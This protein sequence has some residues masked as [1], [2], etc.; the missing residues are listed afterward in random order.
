[1]TNRLIPAV[2]LVAMLA[3]VSA[4]PANAFPYGAKGL[5][6]D[7]M[8]S[9]LSRMDE[10]GDRPHAPGMGWDLYLNLDDTPVL[11]AELIRD[12]H[13]LQLVK[14]ERDKNTFLPVLSAQMFMVYGEF[15][16]H[17]VVR[18]RGG[19]E[20]RSRIS[21]TSTSKVPDPG[22]PVLLRLLFPAYVKGEPVG[23]LEREHTPRR[24]NPGG[25]GLLRWLFEEEGVFSG[26]QWD[27]ENFLPRLLSVVALVV[28]GLLLI[29][30]LRLLVMLG[31]KTVGRVDKRQ[32]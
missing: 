14:F 10:F 19:V 7:E 17:R 26:S 30:F 24:S 15:A 8:S 16:H 18:Q 5:V 25:Y 11:M 2:L 13:W 31:I 4:C 27:W 20:Q 1:L 21:S 29:E 6:Q 3:A 32:P 12:E 9:R 22:I 23:L 28:A